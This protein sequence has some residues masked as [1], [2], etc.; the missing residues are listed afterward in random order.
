[1]DGARTGRRRRWYTAGVT[2]VLVAALGQA[3][4]VDQ[5]AGSAP[6][7]GS[8][9]TVDSAHPSGRMPGDFVGLSYEMR[10]LSAQCLTG[11]CTGNFAADRGDLVALLKNLGVSNVRIA[12]NQLDRD[13]LWVPA[14]QQPPD[15]LPSWTADVVT[16]TDIARL[17]GV[18]RRTGWKAEV[19]INLAHYDPALAADEAHTLASILGPRLAGVECGNEPNHYASNGYRTAPYGFAQH[20]QDWEACAALVGDSPIAA[21]DLS[22]PTSTVDWFDQF[23]QAERDRVAMLT[24]HNYTGATTIAQLLSPEIR[25]SELANVAPQLATARALGIPIRLD[26]TNSAVGGGIEGVSDVYAS[27]LWAMDYNLTMAQAG[28]AGLNFHGGFGVCGEPLFNGKYQRYTPICAATA[29]DEQDKIYTAAPEYYGL[30]MA[31]QLASGRFLPVTVSSDHNVTAYAVRGDDERTRIAVIEKD[32]TSGPAVP[33][34]IEVGGRDATASV[35]HLTGSALDSAD[36]VAVQGATVDRHG[37]LDP[38][39]PD[40]VRARHGTVNLDVASGSAVIVTLDR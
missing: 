20:Q 29:Q 27:A 39:R 26:E 10:E 34:S 32:D 5:A 22:S 15:P 21:P 35:V 17:D 28:F 37:R 1:M 40:R 18:L 30:Y 2:A 7:A 14:G 33:V 23:A 6:A 16:P 13:T 36:G 4:A 9:V 19:G 3:V 11:D 24:I 8:V 25:A 12:G 31:S 38:K